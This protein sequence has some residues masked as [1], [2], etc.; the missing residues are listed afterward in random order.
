E[1]HL[2]NLMHVKQRPLHKDSLTEGY[3]PSC[4]R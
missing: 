3:I 4:L 2:H 1:L